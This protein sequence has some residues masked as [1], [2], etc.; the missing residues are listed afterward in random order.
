MDLYQFDE[1][2][3][4]S[5]SRNVP[6]VSQSQTT[7]P[8]ISVTHAS[9][10]HHTAGSSAELEIQ[11]AGY[12]DEGGETSASIDLVD[13]DIVILASESLVGLV[14]VSFFND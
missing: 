8:S 1:G 7:T 14:A 11:E 2:G 5:T 12:G 13:T 6:N 10:R 3:Q 9:P 4:G